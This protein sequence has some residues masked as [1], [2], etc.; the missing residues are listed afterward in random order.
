MKLK[1]FILLGLLLSFGFIN[2]QND[3]RPGYIIKNTGDTISGQIDYRGDLL[4]RKQCKFK[5]NGGDVLKYEPNE[6][7]SFR[8]IDSKYFISKEINNEKVFLEYLINGRLN[9]YYMRDHDGDHYYLESD[10]LKLTE[11]PYEEGTK[12]IDDTEVFYESKK[13]IGLLNY[14]MKDAPKLKSEINSLKKPQHKPLIKLAKK[15]HNT[16]CKNE[17]CII[18]EKVQPWVKVNFEVLAG[19]LNFKNTDDIIN[20]TY[21]QSGFLTHFWMPRTNENIYFKTGILFS[22]V[23]LEDGSDFF[24]I[25]IPAHLGYLAPKTY[26]VRPS[27]SI[28]LLSP[29]YSGGI[30]IKINKYINIGVQS[31]VNFYP[32]GTFIYIP[33]ALNNYSFFGNLYIE[34]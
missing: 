16:T 7:H 1:N 19:L 17:E 9:V 23:D 11:M 20:N 29:S 25:K 14:Y 33:Y 6:I 2:A 15:Y 30:A 26:R 27:L 10:D 34:L 21:F 32:L 8:F 22:K 4:M 13:H 28:G 5:F 12:Y 31:W 3:Y 18:Y 24:H